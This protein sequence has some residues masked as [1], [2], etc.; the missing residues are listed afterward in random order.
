LLIDPKDLTFCFQG[1]I[2]SY[3]KDVIQLTLKHFS[4]SQVT[5]STNTEMNE[6][7]FHVSSIIEKF[8]LNPS[9]PHNK[10]NL[11]RHIYTARNAIEMAETE[12]V[13]K[14]RTDCV[15]QSNNILNRFDYQD[16]NIAVS[17]WHTY[18]KRM[19]FFFS[20]FLYLGRKNDVLK[21]F[22]RDPSLEHPDHIVNWLPTNKQFNGHAMGQGCRPEQ[23]LASRY[24]D[25]KN[26][27]FMTPESFANEEERN[28]AYN[29]ATYQN[30]KVFSGYKQW[31]CECV[32]YPDLVNL[33]RLFDA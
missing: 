22:D 1:P 33:E 4:L 17:N 14:I 2:H 19:P 10:D 23:Y 27:V 21:L 12:F 25:M 24:S 29:S 9:V 5:C 18:H 20:D 26:F 15:L 13:C 8:H 6:D 3:T 32:K 31:H 16:G 7:V 28:F 11:Y 30:F